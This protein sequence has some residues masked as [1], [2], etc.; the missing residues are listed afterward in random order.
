MAWYSRT[1]IVQPP[2]QLAF[3]VICN[4]LKSFFPLQDLCH[5]R[6]NILCEI[7]GKNCIIINVLNILSIGCWTSLYSSNLLSPTKHTCAKNKQC[8]YTCMMVFSTAIS[9]LCETVTNEGYRYVDIHPCFF[10]Y[11]GHSCLL[12]LFTGWHT[13]IFWVKFVWNRF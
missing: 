12:M 4:F 11:A 8:T 6:F 1:I 7:Q 5:F 3:S 13:V 2:L 10:I 9:T